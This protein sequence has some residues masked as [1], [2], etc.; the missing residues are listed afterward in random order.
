MEIILKIGIVLLCLNIKLTV[1]ADC[2]NLEIPILTAEYTPKGTTTFAAGM[3][4]YETG[5]ANSTKIL[6]AVY[7]I[8]GFDSGSN[9]RQICDHLGEFGYRVIMPDFFHGV[10]W[11]REHFPFPN[12]QEFLD[13]VRATSWDESVREDLRLVLDEYRIPDVTEFGIFGFCFGGKIT[14]HAAGEY[15]SDIKVAAQFHPGGVNLTDATLI[16]APTILLPGAN[17]PDMTDYCELI[18]ILLGRGSCVYNHFRDV[19]HGFAG[20]T[21]DWTNATVQAR[22]QEAVGMF[23]QFLCTNFPA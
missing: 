23:E 11:K 10:P 22:A 1:G 16:K 4:T 17:D 20:A 15:S 9:I 18:N 12:D 19:N 14:A 2:S 5:V 3:D 6:I 8:F 21:G 13:F 7:D